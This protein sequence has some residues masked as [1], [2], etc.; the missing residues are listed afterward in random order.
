VI[1]PFHQ[2]VLIECRLF[3]VAGQQSGRTL[4]APDR[5]AAAFCMVIGHPF[6]LAGLLPQ[7]H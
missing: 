3:A 5:A 6:P 7:S 2:R 4:R 1:P